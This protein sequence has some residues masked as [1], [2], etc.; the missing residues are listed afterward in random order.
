MQLRTSTL[1]GTSGGGRGCSVW[2]R[3]GAH[4]GELGERMGRESVRLSIYGEVLVQLVMESWA[5][6][7]GDM[8]GEACG[9]CVGAWNESEC[10]EVGVNGIMES[11]V[12]ITAI[13]TSSSSTRWSG[14]VLHQALATGR[15]GDYVRVYFLPVVQ[16]FIYE[17]SPQVSWDCLW[18]LSV[19]PILSLH[20][21]GAW[22][23]VSY[24]PLSAVKLFKLRV[25]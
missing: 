24:V 13:W 20:G 19:K 4:H 3:G 1:R 12:R 2:L 8:V 11:W 25:V 23:H 6:Y 10:Y 9:L 7:V 17:L 16:R 22:H 18:K 21:S 5:G 14:C 15:C